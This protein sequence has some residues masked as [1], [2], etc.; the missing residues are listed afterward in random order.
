LGSWSGC[1][2]GSETFA[3]VTVGLDPRL[4]RI[5]TEWSSLCVGSVIFAIVV[6]DP[7]SLAVKICWVGC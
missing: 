1:G 5:E 6:E 7:R 4:A 2:G 3:I